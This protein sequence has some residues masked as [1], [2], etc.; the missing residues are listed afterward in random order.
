MA[1][2]RKIACV[3]E[4]RDDAAESHP[5]GL[6]DVFRLNWPD[7]ADLVFYAEDRQ[8]RQRI[9]GAATQ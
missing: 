3:Y 5:V 9:E 7:D 1:K 4:P 8:Y 2:N 6:S